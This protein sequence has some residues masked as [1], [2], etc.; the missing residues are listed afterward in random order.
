MAR[1]ELLEVRLHGERIGTLSRVGEVVRFAADPEYIAAA[2]RPTLSLSYAIPAA[3]QQHKFSDR[4]FVGNVVTGLDSLPP[5]FANLVPESATLRRHIAQR[6]GCSPTDDFALLAASGADL[7]G[8]TTVVP[9]EDPTLN[10]VKRH[11]PIPAS[12]RAVAVRPPLDACGALAGVH[13]KAA[14]SALTQHRRLTLQWVSEGVPVIVKFPDPARPE[15]VAAEHLAM[16]LARAAGAQVADTQIVPM[17]QMDFA[18]SGLGE[19]LAD[20]EIKGGALVVRRFDR[21]A[22]QGA[23]R[24]HCEDFCQIMARRPAEKYAPDVTNLYLMRAMSKVGERGT[25]E[26]EEVLRRTAI[27]V[28]IGNSDAHRKNWSVIYPDRRTPTLAP[29]YDIVP[30]SFFREHEAFAVEQ[31]YRKLSRDAL[32]MAATQSGVT[33]DRAAAIIE[34]VV[35]ASQ[36]LWPRLIAEAR[37]PKG[38][39]DWLAERSRK[40]LLAERAATG[41]RPL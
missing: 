5:F 13:L 7:P 20:R 30:V 33:R 38:F 2:D 22:T 23:A 41:P 40:L 29:A 17:S 9:L 12:V 4:E 16:A 8:A 31:S 24:V 3:H 27:N 28:L 25:L 6:R 19:L 39:G 15:L 35:E 36:T 11:V 32:V 37:A 34:S 10:D 14:M 21:G 1:L 18:G 26:A